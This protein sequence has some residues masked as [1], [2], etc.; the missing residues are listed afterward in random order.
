M[1][2]DEKLNGWAKPLTV[3][4]GSMAALITAML[5][6]HKLVV[7]PTIAQVVDQHA[8]AELDDHVRLLHSDD[9]NYV[10]QREFDRL[11]DRLSRIERK[12][13]QLREGA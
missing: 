6:F 9:T 2:D 3:A 13:D 7:V 11:L 5:G 10:S 4:V 1:P 8:R 12:I